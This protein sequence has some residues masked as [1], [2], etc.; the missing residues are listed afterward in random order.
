MK[1]SIL[2]DSQ[3]EFLAVFEAFSPSVPGEIVGAL[4]P[5]SG[6]QSARLME[7]IIQDRKSVV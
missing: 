7:Q 3:M 1:Q 5:Y 4:V 6:D 2:S